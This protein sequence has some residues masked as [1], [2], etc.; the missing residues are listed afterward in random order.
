[1][2]PGEDPDVH[3]RFETVKGFDISRLYFQ[4]G[5]GCAF[6][7]LTRRRR[8]GGEMGVNAADVSKVHMRSD[9]KQRRA[10]GIEQPVA[11]SR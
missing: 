4:T 3:S 9:R 10:R 2:E 11:N 1:M 6:V 8:S 7:G 5:V